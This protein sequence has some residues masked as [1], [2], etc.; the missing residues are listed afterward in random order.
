[1]N[2][3]DI[4]RCFSKHVF[5]LG[6]DCHDTL[7]NVI[8]EPHRYHDYQ[9]VLSTDGERLWFTSSRPVGG[10]DPARQN[11]WRATRKAGWRDAAPVEDL[12]S[13]FWDGH[14]VEIDRNRILFAS[15]RPSDGQMVDLYEYQLTGTEPPRRVRTLS[16]AIT[17][18]DI[19]FDPGSNALVQSRFD[20]RTRDIDLFLAF[21]TASDWSTPRRLTSLSTPE[22]E[23]S[24]CF[25]PDGR[26]LLFKRGA[27]PFRRVPLGEVLSGQEQQ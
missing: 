4:F 24:P 21:R 1:M 8:I 5:C 17:D 23:M 20:P 6:T 15:E 25:S 16:S 19:A 12:V 14:A 18:N 2:N 11:V 13:P 10:D 26:Y 27:T 3:P 7:L 22:W 9:P